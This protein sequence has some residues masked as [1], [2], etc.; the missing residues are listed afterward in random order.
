MRRGTAGSVRQFITSHRSLERQILL[1]KDRTDCKLKEG[2]LMEKTTGGILIIS[3]QEPQ[4]SI[5]RSFCCY[6]ILLLVYRNWKKLHIMLWTT[7]P[8]TDSKAW[9]WLTEME[10]HHFILTLKMLQPALS[11]VGQPSLHDHKQDN[12]KL[13]RFLCCILSC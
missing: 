13:A 8:K 11:I 1:H 4:G 9:I 5:C 3:Q 7:R 12:K 6:Y 2:I 10:S